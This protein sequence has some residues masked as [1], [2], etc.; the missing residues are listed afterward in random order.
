MSKN[1]LKIGTNLSKTCE[2][3]NTKTGLV[4]FLFMYSTPGKRRSSGYPTSSSKRYKSEKKSYRKKTSFVKQTPYGG[5]IVRMPYNRA[6]NR[7]PF[8]PK[9]FN[10]LRYS[11]QVVLNTSDS[12]NGCGTYIWSANNLYDPNYTGTGHQPLYYDQISSLYNHWTV[13]SSKITATIVRASNPVQLQAV[14][15]C[16]DDATLGTS[17][18]INLLIERSD[19][20]TGACDPGNGLLMTLSQTFSAKKWFG[21]NPL[22][23]DN[24]QGTVGGGPTEQ[25]YYALMVQDI[26]GTS[27]SVAIHVMMEFNVVWDELTS[28]A[29]S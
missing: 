26:T 21:A 27:Q 16:D 18:N 12:L 22:A 3:K 7:N 20:S 19:S 5:G 8:P 11:E 13:V 25:V 15:V 29:S 24:L 10:T 17:N 9:L 2:P 6:F 1:V 23:N 14:L 28:V 4:V